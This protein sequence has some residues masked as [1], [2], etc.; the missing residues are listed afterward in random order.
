[1]PYKVRLDAGSLGMEWWLIA[2]L[3][4]ALIWWPYFKRSKRMSYGFNN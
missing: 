2:A 4:Q 1:M 3:V